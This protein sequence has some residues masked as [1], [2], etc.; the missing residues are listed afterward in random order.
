MLIL[1]DVKVCCVVIAH[2]VP[3]CFTHPY[4]TKGTTRVCKGYLDVY[5][6]TH[7]RFF[8]IL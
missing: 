5:P 6:K 8:S 7:V 3:L 2:I 4:T 1:K